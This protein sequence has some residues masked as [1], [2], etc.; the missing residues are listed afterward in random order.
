MASGHAYTPVTLH[1]MP[2]QQPHSS[3][4]PPH[5]RPCIALQDLAQARLAE[6]AE[7]LTAKLAKSVDAILSMS[8]AELSRAKGAYSDWGMGEMDTLAA[9]EDE[10]MFACRAAL[11]RLHHLQLLTGVPADSP[12]LYL[13]LHKL[14]QVCC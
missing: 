6:T 8:S 7:E 14:L 12:Q 4:L 3:P 5:I 10:D 9:E 2:V 13:S 11:L 1:S